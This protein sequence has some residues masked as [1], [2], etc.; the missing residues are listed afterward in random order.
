[1]NKQK[2]VIDGAA[3][4]GSRR[5]TRRL[6]AGALVTVIGAGVGAHALAHG[7]PG[8]HGGQG[9]WEGR[10][11]HHGMRD[12]A[13]M[14]KFMEQRLRRALS[15]VGAND[16]QQ[17]QVV[18]IMRTAMTEVR[19]L[20]EKGQ[21]VRRASADALAKPTVDR[22]QLEVLRAEQMQIA[23]QASKRM[24]QAFADVADVLTPEQRAKFV[25]R[26]QRRMHGGRDGVTG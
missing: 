7:G 12:P 26:F 19:P 1:M 17:T 2:E 25:Q 6:V 9:G 14:Q 8:G 10:G 18:E 11:G 15:E 24:S 3:R 4:G 13:Q 22:A 21:S 16:T 23:D 20:R 5:W